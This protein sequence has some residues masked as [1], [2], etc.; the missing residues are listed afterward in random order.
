MS[1]E[2]LHETDLAT[3]FSIVRRHLLE[4]PD[5]AHGW[6]CNIATACMDAMDLATGIKTSHKTGNA[7]AT[8]FMSTCFDV[9][10]S[11]DML[12]GYDDKE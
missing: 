4:N 9:K 3:A 6:H 12:R 11:N 1:K 10:T 5:Y 8:R 2:N 7:A